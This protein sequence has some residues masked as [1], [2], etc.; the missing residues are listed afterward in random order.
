MLVIYFSKDYKQ[1]ELSCENVDEVDSWKASFLRAGVYPEKD[2]ATSSEE[3][4]TI[5]L[6]TILSFLFHFLILKIYERQTKTHTKII[7]KKTLRIIPKNPQI[8]YFEKKNL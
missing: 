4:S 3:V 7:Y 1:L 2:Q 8:L 6:L 5:Q